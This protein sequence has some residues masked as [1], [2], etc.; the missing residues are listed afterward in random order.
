MRSLLLATSPWGPSRASEVL[1]VRWSPRGSSGARFRLTSFHP[2]PYSSHRTDPAGRKTRRGCL[3][4]NMQKTPQVCCPPSSPASA[5]R[6]G[7][8]RVPSNAWRRHG[9]ATARFPV[10]TPSQSS[11]ASRLP[12]SGGKAP[13]A[14]RRSA[15]PAASATARRL[16]SWRPGRR[17]ALPDS[18]PRSERR[19]R[20]SPGGNRC[21][22]AGVLPA[23]PSARS[24]ALYYQRL[25]V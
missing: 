20:G 4:C 2:Q 19:P 8:A 7:S 1:S 24:R 6:R 9:T 16:R 13:S 10:L 11:S 18:A 25:S 3:F 22:L 5:Q 21:P 23:G 12:C 14:P 15:T 17:R